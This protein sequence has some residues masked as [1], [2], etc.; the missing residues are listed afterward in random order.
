VDDLDTKLTQERDRLVAL[1]AALAS[2]LDG[3]P[4]GRLADVL[5]TVAGLD[6]VVRRVRRLGVPVSVSD[7]DARTQMSDFTPMAE[8]LQGASVPGER[9]RS[10]RF[11]AIVRERAG[12]FGVDFPDLP[13]CI[14]AGTS[15]AEA[16]EMAAR[17]L[18]LHVD[19]MIA[20]GLPVPVP[21]DLRTIRDDPDCAVATTVILVEV[22]TKPN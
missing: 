1:L 5:P 2:A 14:T 4:V 9:Q 11:V 21:R 18:R 12:S 3:L 20:K 13:G 19:D 16:R 7:R 17:T 8:P 22:P 15:M 6:G 10:M